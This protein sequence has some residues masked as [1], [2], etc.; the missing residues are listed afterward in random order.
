M[1]KISFKYFLNFIF[2]R[3]L[4]RKC[5]AVLKPFLLTWNGSCT[6]AL[7]TTEVNLFDVPSAASSLASSQPG[8]DL[9][10]L[11]QVTTNWPQLQRSLSRFAN[12][13]YSALLE[14]G[15][16]VAVARATVF[17]FCFWLHASIYML[18]RWMKSRCAQSATCLRAKKETT[19]F[20]SPV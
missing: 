11:F 16:C 19:G 7:S 6:T 13:R 15:D 1:L 8:A 14:N 5:T 4:K 18:C 10:T 20:A 12:M 2:H 3:I 9:P 17:F